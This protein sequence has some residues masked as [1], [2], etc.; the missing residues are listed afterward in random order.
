MQNSA[1][2]ALNVEFW[3][4]PSRPQPR[5]YNKSTN[6]QPYKGFILQKRSEKVSLD[7]IVT[8]LK[9]EKGL[10]VDKSLQ[11]RAEGKRRT[12]FKYTKTGEKISKDKI[13]KILKRYK[14]DSQGSGS[15]NLQNDDLVA[16]TPTASVASGPSLASQAPVQDEQLAAFQRT[17]ARWLTEDSTLTPV[18]EAMMAMSLI[19]GESSIP[20]L[21]Q[22]IDK[23]VPEIPAETLDR[24]NPESAA[25]READGSTR[26]SSSEP[27]TTEGSESP[28][29]GTV[30]PETAAPTNVRDA[31]IQEHVDHGMA[32]SMPLEAGFHDVSVFLRPICMAWLERVKRN[33]MSVIAQKPV[34]PE[35]SVEEI[36]RLGYTPTESSEP[37]PL[38]VCADILQYLDDN[39]LPERG[40]DLLEMDWDPV[41]KI[42]Y[43]ALPAFWGLFASTAAFN[44]VKLYL[45]DVARV[46]YL[47]TLVTRYGN[48]NYFVLR[49]MQSFGM[50][51]GLV[52][53]PNLSAEVLQLAVR[54]FD[55]LGLRYHHH[56]METYY[57]LAQTLPFSLKG[58]EGVQLVQAYLLRCQKKYGPQHGRTISAMALLAR[59]LVNQNQKPMAQ[60]LLKHIVAKTDSI[61]EKKKTS[62][63]YADALR[64][65][66]KA[67]F[68]AGLNHQA[69]K[70]LI[71]ALQRNDDLEH[72]APDSSHL[73]FLVGM[74][75]GQM[76]QWEG[77][78]TFLRRSTL[79]RSNTFGELHRATGSSME[80]LSVVWERRGIVRYDN[81]V[82]ELLEKLFRHYENRFG[83]DHQRTWNAWVKYGSA[84]VAS[85]VTEQ[86]IRE[87]IDVPQ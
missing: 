13:D 58:Q 38:T 74:I 46:F 78:I 34:E 10:D 9:T 42:Y 29:E 39:P 14:N 52:C 51:L 86:R 25:R 45:D 84:M 15:Q 16:A 3:P 77:A 80:A 66:G 20:D 6:W 30:A 43:S 82:L 83:E 8:L 18:E 12:V 54:G 53:H 41:S 37:L 87:F 79:Y 65:I 69:A 70:T 62:K 63:Q 11:R 22:L 71:L 35:A 1:P 40:Y 32:V 57:Q 55:K 2:A 73:S 81:P 7:E 33:A 23:S 67:E 76:Q 27:T 49:A 50:C 56:T 61:P 59:G 17:T 28:S 72:R 64:D 4:G 85:N 5:R 44:T 48:D 31:A 26:P 24:A 60:A 75:Y 36:G 19:G 47:P 68:Y 21:Y